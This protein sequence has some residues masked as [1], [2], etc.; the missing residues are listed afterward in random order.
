MAV[1][2]EEKRARQG[3]ADPREALSRRRV[4][5]VG[6]GVTGRS[7]ARFLLQSGATVTATDTRGEADLGDMDELRAEGA[8][9]KAG[10]TGVEDVTRADLVVISPG[11]PA[12]AP[13]LEEARREGIEVIGALELAARFISVPIIAVAGTNGKSTVTT[14]I[15]EVMKR[16][17]MSVFVGGNIGTPALDYFLDEDPAK[18]CVLEVSSFQLETIEE[19]SPHI[20]LLL[21]ITDD[22]LDRYSGFEEYASV[23]LRLFDNQVE[24]DYAV[25]NAADPLIREE[26]L[27]GVGRG[28]GERVPFACEGAVRTGLWHEGGEI[29]FAHNGVVESYAMDWPGLRGGH[30]MENAMAAIGALRL[31]GVRKDDVISGFKAFR[32]LRYRMELVREVRGVRYVNDSKGTNTG[33]LQKALEG[34]PAPV[35]LIAGGRDKGGDYAVL[36]P[37]AARKLRLLIAL[38]EAGERLEEA[39]KGIV[40]VKRASSM[41]EAVRMAASEA[42]AGDT[43]LLSPACSSFDM[44]RDFKERGECF[45]DLVRAL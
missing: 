22:H 26:M 27:R 6:L 8:V 45:S 38:G 16:A 36:Y 18:L 34:T 3:G 5:V 44:F 9:I 2:M 21:N 17:G 28:G 11:V 15:G 41:E 13:F 42:E 12:R 40:E 20:A 23:K 39:F 4:L 10:T 43:V 19:F 35:I 32:G 24:G 31:S 7:A 14:L 1:E 29:F 25:V 33:A 37:E 30:N